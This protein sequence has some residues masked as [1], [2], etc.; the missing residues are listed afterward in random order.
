[1]HLATSLCGATIYAIIHKDLPVK[2]VSSL[3]FS[4]D[5]KTEQKEKGAQLPKDA[6]SSQQG[7][8]RIL[9]QTGYR[10]MILVSLSNSGGVKAIHAVKTWYVSSSRGISDT[11]CW[12]TDGLCIPGHGGHP[13]KW[14][15]SPRE[16]NQKWGVLQHSLVS[17]SQNPTTAPWKLG[18][19][20]S[21]VPWHCKTARH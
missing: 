5:P 12:K 3:W 13:L 8:R 14:V 6:P 11:S 15:A 10:W 19:S 21:V 17:S 9:Q 18:T 4:M 20:C 16:V 1:M 2:Q 7:P